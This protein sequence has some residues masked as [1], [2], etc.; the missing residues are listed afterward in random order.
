MKYPH[1]KSPRLLGSEKIIDEDGGIVSDVKGYWQWAYSDILD[2]TNRGAFA[3]YLVACA[4]GIENTPRVNWD[5]YDLLSGSGIS[6]EVKASGYIQTWDQEELSSLSFNIPPTYGWDSE[7]NT[8][9]EIR[10]RQADVYVF[11]VHKHREQESINPLDISQWEFYVLPTAVLNEKAGE[12]KTA[13]L[14]SLI[15]MGA[16]KCEFGELEEKI[17]E[18]IQDHHEAFFNAMYNHEEPVCPNCGKGRIVCP[19][20]KIEKP[21]TFRCSNNCGWFLDLTPADVIVE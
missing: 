11:C 6:V 21:H 18:V 13:T 1:I 17:E 16:E 7:T 2:N 10:K 5:K 12:Q 4:L 15:N 8:Y 9:S 20:G 19:Q 14:S 3:E